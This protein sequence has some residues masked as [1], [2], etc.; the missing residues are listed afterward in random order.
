MFP[1]FFAAAVA[2]A[3]L[4]GAWME[5][6]TLDDGTEASVTL[7]LG[8]TEPRPIVVGVHGSGDRP[9][10]SCGE[11][12]GVVDSYAFVVCPHGTP[13]G[14]AFV[15]KSSDQVE[16]R[17]MAALAAARAKYG[18]YVMDGPAIYAGFSQG[19]HMAA[20]VVKRHP[21]VFTL[22]ALDE[23]GYWQTGGDF[24]ATFA[25]GGGK[26][27]LLMCSTPGCQTNFTQSQ[28]LLQ[29]SGVDVRVADLGPFGHTINNDVIAAIKPQWKWLVRDD[30]RWAPWLR[31][32]EP[33]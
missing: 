16:K 29:K 30:P 5:T 11:W 1:L 10:W 8:A 14:N 12:R 6:V 26:R 24:A 17:V 19:A 32:L 23:G 22:I 27:A 18:L 4:R 25:R 31:T 33:Q 20:A 21:D 9:E 2:L 15:W 28:Q 3:P 13:S 7:P